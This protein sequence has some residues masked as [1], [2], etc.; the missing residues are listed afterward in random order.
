MFKQIGKA[1][2]YLGDC[3]E[4]MS[5]FQSELVDLTVTSPPY[6]NLRTNVWRIHVGANKETKVHPAVFPESLANDHI[7][8]W[9][10]VG[11]TVLDPFMGS[12]TTGKMV[13]LNYRKF[14][15]I[16]KV[17][18]YFEISEQRISQTYENILENILC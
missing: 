1:S 4:V 9:S 12:A 13:L 10:K 16:E 2:I 5:N 17:P 15:G 7:I 6:D 14:I 3:L 8:S 11:D 18:E